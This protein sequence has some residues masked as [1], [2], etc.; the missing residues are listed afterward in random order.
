MAKKLKVSDAMV[1][2]DNIDLGGRM[3]HLIW[4]NRAFGYAEQFMKCR[5]AERSA[6][7]ILKRALNLKV[8]DLSAI[9]YGALKAGN[10]KYS[11]SQYEKDYRIDDFSKYILT[12]EK[13]L[14]SFLPSSGKR[15]SS[16]SSDGEINGDFF[17]DYFEMARKALGMNED[18]ILNSSIKI[19][20]NLL[21]QKLNLNED[22]EMYIDN[23][24][25]F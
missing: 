2:E 15:D 1:F 16:E 25:G 10:K 11:L 9:L 21:R 17:G 14:N 13:G 23:I 18:D 6:E 19:I 4:N 7:E 20:D 8:V 5:N 22:E 3:R 24:P 12:V